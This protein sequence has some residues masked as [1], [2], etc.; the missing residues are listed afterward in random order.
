VPSGYEP[1]YFSFFCA[2]SGYLH[3]V[4]ILGVKVALALLLRL[5]VHL[6]PTTGAVAW[7]SPEGVV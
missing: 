3:D 2:Q 4:D 6:T 1:Q 7:R 5:S